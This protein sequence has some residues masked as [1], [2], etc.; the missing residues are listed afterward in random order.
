MERTKKFVSYRSNLYNVDPL[1][2]VNDSILNNIIEESEGN[3]LFFQKS[4]IEF[5]KIVLLIKI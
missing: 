5:L 1:S 4:M 2:S 3:K